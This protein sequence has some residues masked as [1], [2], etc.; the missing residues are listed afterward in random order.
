MKDAN[1]LHD[2]TDNRRRRTDRDAR[3]ELRFNRKARVDPSRLYFVW[4]P[5]TRTCSPIVIATML[6]YMS[7]RYSAG[8]CVDLRNA[9]EIASASG[10]LSSVEIY[11][12]TEHVPRRTVLVSGLLLENSC[13]LDFSRPRGRVLARSDDADV[14]DERADILPQDLGRKLKLGPSFVSQSLR[15]L[16]ASVY[17]D[18]TNRYIVKRRLSVSLRR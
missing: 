14:L 3:W 9:L 17:T 11:V 10:S 7:L 6:F 8:P 1:C 12:I 5:H 2:A 16:H 4:V 13:G 18:P 15:Q